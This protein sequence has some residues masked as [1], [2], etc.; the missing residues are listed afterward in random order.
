MCPSFPASDQEARERSA[1]LHGTTPKIQLLA[2]VACFLRLSRTE[3]LLLQS[4]MAVRTRDEISKV[5]AG[6]RPE[7]CCRL[8]HSRVPFF[9]RSIRP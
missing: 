8:F 3:L 9:E 4:R 6:V 5:M 7:Y 1:D 2:A